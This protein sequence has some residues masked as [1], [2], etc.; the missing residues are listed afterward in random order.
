[1]SEVVFSKKQ[2]T[3]LLEK[4]KITPDNE[5]FKSIIR[6]FN[7]QTNYQIWAIKLV[8]SGIINIEK[9]TTIRNW[10]D[11]NQ[12]EIQNLRGKNIIWYNNPSRIGELFKE[13]QGLDMIS[14]VKGTI[15]KFNTSQRELLRK[16]ILTNIEDGLAAMGS[17]TFKSW[18]ELF[19]RMEYLPQYKKEKLISLASAIDD[20][21]FLK[22]H[23]SD[24]LNKSYEWNHD[25]MLAFMKNNASDC[26]VTFDNNNIVVISVPSFSSSKKMCGNGRTGWCITREDRYFRQYV[27]EPGNAHQYMLFNFNLPENHELAHIGFTVRD[28]QGITNAHSCKNQSMTGSGAEVDGKRITITTALTDCGVPK[29]MYIHLKKLVKYKWG[30]VEVLK[31]VSEYPNDFAI[32]VNENNRL[33]IR[34]MTDKGFNLIANHTLIPNGSIRVNDNTKVYILM[35]F[36][37][38]V[39]DD[40]AFV[41]FYY[42]KDTYGTVSLSNVVDAYNSKRDINILSKLNIPTSKFLNRE[43]I[44][45][46]ILIHKL[47]NEGIEDEVLKLIDDE[48]EDFDINYEF[49]GRTPIH[50]AILKGM[51]KVFNAIVSHKNFDSSV[52]DGFGEPLLQALIYNYKIEGHTSHDDDVATKKMIDMI[53]ANDNFDFNV[54]NINLDTPINVA[55]EDVKYM[56][57]VEALLAK[58]NVDVNTV[59]DIGFTALGNAIRNKNIHAIELLANREGTIVSNKDIE[60]AK[61]VG[62]DLS[63]YFDLSS[64]STDSSSSSSTSDL[65]SELFAKAFARIRG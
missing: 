25:D 62:I 17:S 19:K 42:T 45:P 37:L 15:G 49:N 7:D 31:F 26:K 40:N 36:N 35:D 65:Y 4:Y 60:T 38:D 3:P 10:A 48:G 12:H 51:Y 59:N 39:N 5:V 18:Y 6:M 52:C 23:I 33:I 34:P 58:P 20:V 55:C 61:S 28:G 44:A 53:L 46:T 21:N 54:V 11:A 9:L 30:I 27:I 1:M 47:I 63:K 13:M 56:W 22:R 8:F 14:A 57:I 29:N 50:S 41:V 64:V 32:S 2:I 24:A 16:A 43:K